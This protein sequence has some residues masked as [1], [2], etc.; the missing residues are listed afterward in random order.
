M[1]RVS[2]DLGGDPSLEQLP[3]DE[4]RERYAKGAADSAF[5]SLVFQYGRYLT[6]AGS[7]ADSPLPLALQGLWNDGLASSASWTNDFHIDM[8]TQQNYWA[9]EVGNLA[10]S[11]APLMTL[12]KRLSEA[13]KTTAQ[14]MYGAEGW[15]AHTVTNAWGFSAPGSGPGWGMHVTGGAWIALH[16]WDHYDYGRDIDF[17]R[18]EAYSVLR[19]SAEFFASYMTTEPINGYLVTGP[20]D[21]PE[22]W[23]LASDGRRCA[24][25]MG[26]TCDRVFVDA[27]FRVAAESARILGIDEEWASHLDRLR[28]LLPP[29]QVGRHGQLQE[30]LEDFD[31]A[32]PSHRHTSHLCAVYPE[33]QIGKRTSPDLADAV[34]VTI[35]RRQEAAGW[36]QTEW[37]EANMITYF[38]RLGDGDEAYSHVRGLIADTAETNL[39]TF[40]AGGVAGAVENIYSFDGNPGCTAGMA[41]M[42]VQG[43][44]SEIELLPAL[45]GAWTTGSVSGLRLRGG[46]TIDLSWQG[47]E[48]RAALLTSSGEGMTR[49]R[50]GEKVIT[51]DLLPGSITELTNENF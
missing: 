41:E 19:G 3:T 49:I 15:V 34:R 12:V 24:V 42:L 1:S 43:D 16:L 29:F 39:M 35:R 28:A 47:G 4:R 48:L 46:H 21:S 36:E 40:S 2:I 27:I 38:A 22:N 9:A 5:E 8:N 50:Y 14:H 45:P 11:H 30:W 31:E 44:G 33:F 20:S 37:V 18:D 25:S 7:R 6:V 26:N 17:L 23:Y 13:G 10:E 51:I 32:I